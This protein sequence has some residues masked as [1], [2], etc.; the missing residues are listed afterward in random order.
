MAKEKVPQSVTLTYEG[1]SY[2]LEFNRR[3]VERM[4]QNGFSLNDLAE[5]PLSMTMKLVQGAFMMHHKGISPDRVREIWHAQTKRD[6]LLS[7][8][9]QMYT[10]PI[11]TLLGDDAD[12]QEE[13]NPTWEAAY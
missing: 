9:I 8:L 3:A 13:E 2:T 5:K 12:E 6:A 7:V 10:Q 4:E 11:N 1:N